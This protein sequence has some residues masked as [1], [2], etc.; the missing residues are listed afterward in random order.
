M[1][2]VFLIG[3]MGS[4]K[5][6]TAQELASLLKHDVVDLDQLIERA[7][8]KSINQFFLEDGEAAFRELEKKTLRDVVKEKNQVVATGGGIVLVSDNVKR[9]RQ[10]GVVV[11]L[12]TDPA[13]LWKRVQHVKDRPL[14]KSDSPQEK[15]Q[16]LLSDRATRYETACHHVV[17]T[18]HQAP[19][20]VA[21]EI[22][23]WMEREK[24]QSPRNR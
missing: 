1:G 22:Q 20:G 21:K 24:D 12:K 14:L 8:K 9:M 18:D 5:T 23:H 3:M 10:S 16:S 2:N 15:L 17:V 19:E 6:R 11:Y 7:A 13:I 4:G